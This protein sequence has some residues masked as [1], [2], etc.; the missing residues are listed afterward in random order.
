MKSGKEYLDLA[1]SNIQ[2]LSDIRT[3]L[4]FPRIYHIKLQETSTSTI[5]P[6]NIRNKIDE[7]LL[8]DQEA[9]KIY[10]ELN[11]QV[12]NL[13]EIKKKCPNLKSLISTFSSNDTDPHIQLIIVQHHH[14]L[15]LEKKIYESM[16]EIEQLHYRNIL[17]KQELTKKF[18]KILAKNK[19]HVHKPYVKL[20]ST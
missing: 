6:N 13:E 2:T 10:E 19:N 4:I 12:E 18:Q 5:M 17:F 9:T 15:S 7:L 11:L 14:L 20:N 3:Q 8:I 1:I 16:D